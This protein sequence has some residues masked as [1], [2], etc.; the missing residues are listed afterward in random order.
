MTEQKTH[1]YKF[2]AE[3]NQLL[4]I[5]THSLYTNR[6]I[7]LRELVSNAS[8]ALEKLRLETL[9]GAKVTDEK[10]PLEIVIDMD[11]EKNILTV[12]DTGIGMTED[13]LVTNIG[14]IAK[15]GTT[16]FLKKMVSDKDQQENIIGK[17]GVGFYSVFMVADEV[18][19]TSR[20]F[21]KT[22]K[23]VEWKSE[24]VT[25]FEIKEIGGKVQRGTKIEIHLKED[26]K[27]FVEKFKLESAITKH[28]NFVPFPIK[29]EK[30]QVN[31]VRAL[32]REP[33]F[34]L[35]DKDYEEFYK[36]LT[37]DSEKQLDTL[38]ISVDA[39][40]Q[41]NALM[42]IPQKSFDMFGMG[43]DEHGL[44]LYVKRVL[45]QHE[46]KDLLPEYLRFIRGVV[47]SEDVPLNISRETLQENLVINK[48]KNNLVSQILSHLQKMAK[49]NEK[50]Y[51]EFW[52]VYSKYFK[53]GYSDYANVEKFAELLRFNSSHDET[54]DG[55]TSFAQ[56]V[57]RVKENQKE[58]YYLT[59]P[60][61]DAV[62]SNPY[63]EIFKKKGMEVLFLYEPVDEFVMDA[64]RKYKDFDLKSVEHVDLEKMNEMTDVEEVKKAKGL[65][66]ED[67]K[68]FDNL[69][70]RM[71]DVL[72]DRVTDVV[73][74]KRLTDSPSCLVSPDGTM[75]SSMQ[76]IMNLMNK[77]ATPPQKSMEINKDHELVRNLLKIYKNSAK[78][79][80]LEQIT[81]QLYESALLLEGYLTDPHKMV[82]RIQDILEKSTAWYL[83]K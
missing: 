25:N 45:I 74:S 30:E 22:A 83:K 46:N 65:S 67:S 7:F 6:E 40:V 47:D 8:D 11:K 39:P 68:S 36:F 78:D 5:L 54:A 3:V 48:I 14:T 44:D 1:K 53:M 76:K 29:I 12:T 75:T 61:R 21:Q 71:K 64:L 24:G 9:K 17:F 62:E 20:S 58:I 15:S 13:E 77:E 19:I 70:R 66:K 23:A 50:Q 26:A 49:D 33:K 82:N 18:V 42:F 4:D 56:Y 57:E 32:W 81:E 28:S 38:H 69:L 37:Y 52:K 60:S 10:L 34:Q 79:K 31:K 2:K 51:F 43:K 63:L 59:L 72:G 27:D 73:E 55:L 16:E 41:F 80:Y 35:K